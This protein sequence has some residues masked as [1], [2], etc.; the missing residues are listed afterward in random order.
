MVALQLGH[1]AI[2]IDI[3]SEYTSEARERL[4]AAP[5]MYATATDDQKEEPGSGRA[6][7]TAPNAPAKPKD[8]NVIDLIDAKK[9]LGQKASP[10]KVVSHS[11]APAKSKRAGAAQARASRKRL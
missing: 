8:G 4:A 9:S 2:T 5:A 3:N 10:R 7:S 6:S 1:R 11:P